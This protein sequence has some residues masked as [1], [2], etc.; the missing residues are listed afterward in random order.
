[1][2][3]HVF[4]AKDLLDCIVLDL[5][6]AEVDQGLLDDVLIVGESVFFVQQ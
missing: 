1:M 3:L 4:V 6:H 5:L 2:H